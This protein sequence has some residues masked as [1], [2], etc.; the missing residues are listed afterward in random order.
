MISQTCA[1]ACAGTASPKHASPPLGFTVVPLPPSAV[2]PSLI[3]RSASPA[4]QSPMFSYQSS[5]SAEE[6]S[7]TSA[8]DM[9]SGPM[10][11]WS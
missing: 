5:S 1:I 4:L 10:P 11:A 8:T 6:R 3:S 2:S 7:Y 9:S